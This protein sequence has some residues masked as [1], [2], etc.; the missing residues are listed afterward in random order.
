MKKIFF[1]LPLVCSLIACTEQEEKNFV[2]SEDT[3]HIDRKTVINSSCIE[4]SY[5]VRYLSL[6]DS[7]F[8]KDKEYQLLKINNQVSND[9]SYQIH[10]QRWS[11]DSIESLL[12]ETEYSQG[13]LILSFPHQEI[14]IPLETEDSPCGLEEKIFLNRYILFQLLKERIRDFESLLEKNH[15]LYLLI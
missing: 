2:Y 3:Y 9:L 4:A 7:I 10:K 14:T 15:D 1:V 12:E 11:K 8:W 5:K 6:I 13:V